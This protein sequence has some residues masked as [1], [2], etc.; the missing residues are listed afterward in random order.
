MVP[1]I[2]PLK[3]GSRIELRVGQTLQKENRPQQLYKARGGEL[4]H[5]MLASVRVK[6][7]LGEKEGRQTWVKSLVGEA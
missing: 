2:W 4:R 5:L 6:T 3:V 7:P 1:E